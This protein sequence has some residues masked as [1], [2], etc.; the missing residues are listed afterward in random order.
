MMFYHL[1][2][3]I[4]DIPNCR[5]WCHYVLRRLRA[6]F[7]VGRPLEVQM[8]LRQLCRRLSTRR[9]ATEATYPGAY[10]ADV[11]VIGGGK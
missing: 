4:I 10:E 7:F 5:L 2:I 11:C 3:A 1:A 8:R 6:N 9:F